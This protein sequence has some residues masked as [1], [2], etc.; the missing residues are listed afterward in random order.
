MVS[1]F[2]YPKHRVEEYRE[3]LVLSFS[4]VKR[5]PKKKRA[6]VQGTIRQVY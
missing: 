1:E 6:C 4:E 2:E 5:S 3:P